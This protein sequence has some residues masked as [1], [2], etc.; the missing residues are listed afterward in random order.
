MKSQIQ[1]KKKNSGIVKLLIPITR[2]QG[3]Y[4]V[5]IKSNRLKIINLHGAPL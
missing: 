1:N 2:I 3:T 4:F 5:E